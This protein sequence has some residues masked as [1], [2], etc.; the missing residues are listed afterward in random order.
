VG[1]LELANGGT[2]F[3]AEVAE[4]S[5]P[6]QVK[7][8]RVL[9]EREFQRLGDNRN[10]RVDIRL[11]TAT[12]QNLYEKVLQGAFREDL[13]YRLSVFPLDLPPLRERVEDIPLLVSH[14]IS[15]FNKHMGKKIR[16]LG[17]GVRDTL[18][19]Y[20]WPG[21]VRELA[22]AVEY[23]FVHCKETLI[24]A[25]DLPPRIQDLSAMSVPSG[26]PGLH[27]NLEEAE[28]EFILKG[29]EAA[30]WKMSLAARRLGISLP[31]LW[32]KM[33]KYGIK[34]ANIKHESGLSD[35]ND[36]RTSGKL[37]DYLTT[38]PISFHF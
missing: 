25:A 27:G 2:L 22:N 9:E 4:I 15:K 19:S 18:E 33:E 32:R 21:N 28:R 7:L 34:R 20:P 26:T 35:L 1:K 37:L 8:L 29:L 38:G 30:N 36:Q 3:L 17:H 14:F 16:G 11:V 10:I 23:A 12:N 24:D 5:P 31:T 6:V 13:Y